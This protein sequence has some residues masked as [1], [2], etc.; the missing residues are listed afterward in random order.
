MF[1]DLLPS[2]QRVHC[3]FCWSTYRAPTPLAPRLVTKSDHFQSVHGLE[4]LVNSVLVL[5]FAD[6]VGDG[7]F[8]IESTNLITQ[9]SLLPRGFSVDNLYPLDT[10][11]VALP[12]PMPSIHQCM[13]GETM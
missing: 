8:S 5:G 2:V 10:W 11:R 1:F 9:W 3:P 4:Y 7:S 6:A 12:Y 13:L